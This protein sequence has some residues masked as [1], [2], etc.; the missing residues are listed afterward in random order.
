VWTWEADG[1]IIQ[2]MLVENTMSDMDAPEE[3]EM[4]SVRCRQ[5]G[6]RSVL[7]KMR[8]G[9]EDEDEDEADTLIETDLSAEELETFDREWEG[10]LESKPDDPDTSFTFW[11][12]SDPNEMNND[13][14]E[15]DQ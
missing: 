1:V 10:H 12:L 9:E 5:I 11:F 7:E 8:E 2:E 4:S 3:V 15:E 6:D 14:D 13:Q